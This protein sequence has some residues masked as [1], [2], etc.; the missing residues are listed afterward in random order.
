MIPAGSPALQP[1]LARGRKW[2]LGKLPGA[3]AWG[4]GSVT[5]LASGVCLSFPGHAE[6]QPGPSSLEGLHT[7]LLSTG[8]QRPST[9][10]LTHLQ[11]FGKHLLT[12]PLCPDLGVQGHS[13]RD[14]S[15]KS[16]APTELM[17]FL[18]VGWGCSRRGRRRRKSR[19]ADKEIDMNPRGCGS[20][21]RAAHSLRRQVRAWGGGL[22]E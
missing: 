4:P 7:G 11:S 5:C 15:D 12:A 13:H 20:L 14:G 21:Q 8:P 1:R 22:P 6:G 17:G 19:D 3:Y 16:P 18:C 9:A 2:T 10:S